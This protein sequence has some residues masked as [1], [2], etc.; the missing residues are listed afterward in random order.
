MIKQWSAFRDSPDATANRYWPVS[1]CRSEMSSHKN[2]VR[3]ARSCWF[4]YRE[5]QL[6]LVRRCGLC[7]DGRTTRYL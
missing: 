2:I 7:S 1:H 5:N 6:T 3:K 4:V